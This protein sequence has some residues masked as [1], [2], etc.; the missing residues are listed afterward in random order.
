M[1]TSEKVR[2]LVES[3][4]GLSIEER[5]EFVSLVVPIDESEVSTEWIAELR[6]RADD[7]DAE[8]VELVDGKDFLRRLR[9]I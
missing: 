9:A 3:Y 7:I 4:A 1:S 5:S 6:S 2:Q 8:R